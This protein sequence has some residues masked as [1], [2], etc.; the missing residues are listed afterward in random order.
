M[1]KT[2]SAIA[3]LVLTTVLAL[4]GAAGNRLQAASSGQGTP[5]PTPAPITTPSATPT[6]HGTPVA[7]PLP[8][9]SPVPNATPTPTPAPLPSPPPLQQV[10]LFGNVT[11]VD[12]PFADVGDNFQAAMQAVEVRNQ[13]GYD[14]WSQ[15]Y[16]VLPSN[17][18]FNAFVNAAASAPPNA[19]MYGQTQFGNVTYI[20]N[21][22]GQILGTLTTTTLMSNPPAGMQCVQYSGVGLYNLWVGPA[23][24]NYNGT[25]YE[26][27]GFTS[28][29][30]II[31]DLYGDG[32][33]DV[34]RGEWLPHAERFNLGRAR[35]F[36]IDGCGEPELAEWMGPRSG[37]L[38]AP[39]DEVKVLGGEQ[40][41]GTAVG[42]VD[43]YRK[44]ALMRDR[45]HDGKITGSELTGLK[46]WIDRNQDGIC[47][48]DELQTVQ[49][50]GI[51]SINCK[52][53]NFASTCVINGQ[54]RLTWD[55]WPSGIK[56]HPAAAL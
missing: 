51:T 52:H 11:N 10:F 18:A 41:F 47:T 27:D 26:V 25:N 13:W 37:L 43:G 32:K 20:L 16:K 5:T 46:V 34:D 1:H 30:P 14:L 8:T 54:I 12:W 23:T 45:N 22:Q 39:L 7:T 36:D 38:V 6:P 53:H 4:S 19:A 28:F 56:L 21:A 35:L 17:G 49:S 44:L 31:I 42:Y 55:W 24:L 15:G 9:S 33:P 48:P 2:K 50:L 3:A 29:S 40:L